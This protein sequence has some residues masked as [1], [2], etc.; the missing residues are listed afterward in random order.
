LIHSEHDIIVP[1]NQSEEMFDE[2]EDAD[3]QVTFVE[4]ED[5]NHNISNAKNRVKTLKVIDHFLKKH[6]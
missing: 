3:K 1:F 2:L 6:I 4:L 5:G